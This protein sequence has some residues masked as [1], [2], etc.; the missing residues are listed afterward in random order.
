MNARSTESKA[1]KLRATPNYLS[2]DSWYYETRTGIDVVVWIRDKATGQL[3]GC[4]QVFISWA[5]I[6]SSLRRW[7][8]SL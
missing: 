8:A 5:D 3:S 7:R 4:G 1:Q 2:D 6:N